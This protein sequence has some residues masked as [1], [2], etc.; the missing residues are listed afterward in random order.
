MVLKLRDRMLEG[1]AGVER[2]FTKG[3]LLEIARSVDLETLDDAGY[4]RFNE[5]RYARNVVFENEQF[6]LVYI[7]WRPGQASSIHD[8]GESWCLYLVLDGEFEEQVF[9]LGDDGEPK[10]TLS[11]RWQTGEITVAAGD[12][13]HRISNDT[14]RDLKTLHIYS[15]PLKQTSK[16]YTPVPRTATP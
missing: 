7:C 10:M 16:N 4:E 5:A 3:E 12:D 9:E 6:E 1:P 11:R 13:I 8:H 2:P 14:D 15:P